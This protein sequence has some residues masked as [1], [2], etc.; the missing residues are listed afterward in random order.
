MSSTLHIFRSRKRGEP[1]WF[2]PQT[3]LRRVVPAAM[4]EA[5]DYFIDVYEDKPE[6]REAF[7]HIR[8]C[9]EIFR[10]RL[11]EDKAHVS[12]QISEF[13]DA[14]SGVPVLVR[15][16]WLH[17]SFRILICVYGLFCRRDS[18]VDQDALK[19]MMEYGR[20]SSLKDLLSEETWAKVK[21]EIQTQVSLL[22]HNR[23][24]KD[25]IAVCEETGQIIEGIQDIAA[26]FI[27]ASGDQDWN[28]K[29]A[30]CDEQFY[31]PDGKSD[32]VNIAMALAYP[33]YSNPTLD[34][35][36]NTKDGKIGM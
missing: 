20:L 23:T 10:I 7:F 35:E 27:N 2:D 19:T 28:S 32:A 11:L 3:D 9:I 21:K 22:V 16:I 24:D 36:L 34:V 29:A 33:T 30:A 25:G 8:N 15:D 12:L 17:G 13:F 5:V 14:L 26:R 1:D 31:T 18:I 6:I 4:M